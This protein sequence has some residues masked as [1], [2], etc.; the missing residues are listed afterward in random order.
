MTNTKNQKEVLGIIITKKE[1]SNMNVEHIHV[2]D[3]AIQTILQS[4]HLNP[5]VQE[6]AIDRM[7]D[8][9]PDY[10]TLEPEEQVDKIKIALTYETVIEY[11]RLNDYIRD[12]VNMLET[13]IDEEGTIV[14]TAFYIKDTDLTKEVFKDELTEEQELQ[15]EKQ[16]NILDGSINIYEEAK[17]RL[18]TMKNTVVPFQN[19]AQRRLTKS[20]KKVR[21][22]HK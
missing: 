1:I 10:F 5:E 4:I 2:T 15:L 18:E 17:K 14:V 8:R 11:L 22:F 20:Q 7:V 21:R 9:T 6:E 19:R 16:M 3:F 13:G 12:E